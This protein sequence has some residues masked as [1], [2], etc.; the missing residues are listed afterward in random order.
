MN[1]ED[2]Q[3]SE[4]P[5]ELITPSAIKPRPV[6]DRINKPIDGVKIKFDGKKKILGFV[7]I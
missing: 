2:A 1:E 4:I 6:I 7:L 3:R 5:L